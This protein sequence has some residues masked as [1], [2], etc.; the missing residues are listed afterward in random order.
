MQHASKK[1]YEILL[2]YSIMKEKIKLHLVQNVQ[3]ILCHIKNNKTHETGTYLFSRY[4]LGF[5]VGPGID[6]ASLCSTAGWYENPIPTQFPSPHSL[7]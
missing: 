1:K 7:F 4:S 6:S 3:A 2:Y 5:P